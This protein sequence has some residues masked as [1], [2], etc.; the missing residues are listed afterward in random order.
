MSGPERAQE[1]TPQNDSGLSTMRPETFMKEETERRASAGLGAS[2]PT[3]LQDSGRNSHSNRS[4]ATENMGV[5]GPPCWK[6]AVQISNKGLANRLRS[7]SF[8]VLGSTL[9]Y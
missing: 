2:V 4:P 5:L 1:A 8:A 7:R 3:C 9:G 6:T